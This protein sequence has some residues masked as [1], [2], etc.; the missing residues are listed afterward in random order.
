M[1]CVCVFAH[2]HMSRGMIWFLYPPKSEFHFSW[3]KY[4]KVPSTPNLSEFFILIHKAADIAQNLGTL[5][6][7]QGGTKEI[8]DDVECGQMPGQPM[9]T[10]LFDIFQIPVYYLNIFPLKK[11]RRQ[12]SNV[13]IW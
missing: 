12:N 5:L 6:Q 1:L 13:V 7:L 3:L 11:N 10:V 2:A 9:E 4:C 8:R